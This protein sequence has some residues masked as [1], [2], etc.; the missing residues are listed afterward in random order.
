MALW[1]VAVSPELKALWTCLRKLVIL[2]AGFELLPS[3]E[4]VV[5]PE[6]DAEPGLR[7]R[8]L[9]KMLDAVAVS[10]EFRAF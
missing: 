9:D 8:M 5:S 4:L 2:S 10:P 3:V 1:A 7:E 6:E